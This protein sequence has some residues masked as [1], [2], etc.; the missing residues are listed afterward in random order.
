MSWYG[1]GWVRD[2]WI[3][4]CGPFPTLGE[5]SRALS[6]AG[7]EHGLPDKLLVMTGAMPPDFV[8]RDA[9]A[10]PSSTRVTGLEDP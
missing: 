6:L 7:R 5:C 2:S 3:R 8:P 9:R 10:K 4:L 1:F